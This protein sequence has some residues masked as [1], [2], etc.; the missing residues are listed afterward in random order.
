MIGL[1]L[2][3][4]MSDAS[5][6]RVVALPFCPLDCFPLRWEGGEHVVRMVFDNIMVDTVSLGVALGTRFNVNVRHARLSRIVFL[7]A[8]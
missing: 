4:Q 2:V 7:S 6:K 1:L 5:D 8:E 3:I